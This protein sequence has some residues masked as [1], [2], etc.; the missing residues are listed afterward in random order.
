MKQFFVLFFLKLSG[1]WPEQW[2]VGASQLVLSDYRG[3]GFLAVIWFGSSPNPF[4]P[5]TVSKLSLFLSLSV[6]CRPS[7]LREWG[8]WR[9]E[10]RSQIVR[11]RESLDLYKEFYTL[12]CVPCQLIL[13]PILAV[14]PFLLSRSRPCPDNKTGGGN[15]SGYTR[16]KSSAIYTNNNGN[17]IRWIGK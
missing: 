9:G 8:G 4:P 5:S 1:E 6:C 10:A 11:P 3:L 13:D 16:D 17:S 14:S 2:I 7:L 15:P 12:W